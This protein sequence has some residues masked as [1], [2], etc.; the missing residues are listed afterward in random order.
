MEHEEQADRLEKE[1]DKLEEFSEEVGD[2]IDETRDD[3]QAKE[4][5]ASV[6]GA[7]EPDEEKVEE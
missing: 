2:R 3:W 6:P 5:D 7:Q 1:A 4:S